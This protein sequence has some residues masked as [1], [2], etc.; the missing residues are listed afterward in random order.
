MRYQDLPPGRNRR[1]VFSNLI[2]NRPYINYLPFDIEV[3]NNR[4]DFVVSRSFS[5]SQSLQNSLQRYNDSPS[6]IENIETNND[7][8]LIEIIEINNDSPRLFDDYSDNYN[9]S[10]NKQNNLVNKSLINNSVIKLN[11]FQ[12]N[13]C[14]ICQENISVCPKEKCIVRIINCSHCFHID[15]IDNWF[16]FNTNCPTCKFNLY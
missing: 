4:L 12:D 6:L 9:Y 5:E 14:V 2:A 13:F 10:T 11:Y 7:S 8:S 1:I 15:C 16:T 3:E